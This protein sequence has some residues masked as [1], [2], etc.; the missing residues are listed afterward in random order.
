MRAGRA[1]DRALALFVTAPPGKDIVIRASSD[2][3]NWLPIFTNRATFQ[4]IDLTAPT[5]KLRFYRATD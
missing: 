1:A 3:R 2:L 4:F 5:N